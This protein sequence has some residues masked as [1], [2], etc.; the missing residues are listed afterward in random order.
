MLEPAAAREYGFTEPVAKPAHSTV[1]QGLAGA[2]L[3]RSGGNP[4]AHKQMT[5]F[6][7][8]RTAAEAAAFKAA[9]LAQATK[10]VTLRP[11]AQ[12]TKLSHRQ[13]WQEFRA[14]TFGMIET[15]KRER[16]F[17]LLP[18]LFQRLNTAN[19]MLDNCAIN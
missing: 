7:P 3:S 10:V 6:N 13:Q 4:T 12:A 9:N 2:Y 19:D 8:T 5:R 15:A 18:Q 16:H 1:K 11:A 14:E 17:H